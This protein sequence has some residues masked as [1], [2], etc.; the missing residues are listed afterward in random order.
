MARSLNPGI[1]NYNHT[2]RLGKPFGASNEITGKTRYS[3]NPV[4][5]RIV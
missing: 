3:E 2:N 4:D 1:L 5:R